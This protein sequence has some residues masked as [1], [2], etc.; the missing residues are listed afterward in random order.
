MPTKTQT[1]TTE[2]TRGRGRPRPPEVIARDDQV[3]ALI[4]EPRTKSELAKL[5]GIEPR[6]V[7]SSLWRLRH[8]GL[9]RRVVNTNGDTERKTH[10]WERVA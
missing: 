3:L 4:T 1:E 6:F 2:D 10:I 5:T 7:Y 9:I 8:A